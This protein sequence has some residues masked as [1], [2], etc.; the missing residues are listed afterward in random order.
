MKN[1]VKRKFE[2]LV[3][4]LLDYNDGLRRIG[5]KPCFISTDNTLKIVLDMENP[6]TES[7]FGIFISQLY[8]TLYE[9]SRYGNNLPND[10]D[11]TLI[12]DE[13]VQL[14]HEYGHDRLV[15]NEREVLKKQMKI[16][17]ILKK[18][19][20]TRTPK[21]EAFLI[22]ASELLN[23]IID[24]MTELIN[25][26]EKEH[27]KYNRTKFI[28]MMYDPKKR[29]NI[30]Q[31]KLT[32]KGSYER[33]SVTPIFVPS[34][35][36]PPEIIPEREC[37]YIPI[38]MWLN[39]NSIKGVK[40]FISTISN[41]W[42]KNLSN[43]MYTQPLFSWSLSDSKGNMVYGYGKKS[44]SKNLKNLTRSVL[45]I[46]FSGDYGK[47]SSDSLMVIGMDFRNDR[48]RNCFVDFYLSSIPLDTH[49]LES[50]KLNLHQVANNISGGDS[51]NFIKT[52]F[53]RWFSPLLDLP[54]DSIHTLI[55]KNESEY[56]SYYDYGV[57]DTELV[58]EW[59]LETEWGEV[60][61][62]NNPFEGLDE[63]VGFLS[64]TLFDDDYKNQDLRV[65]RLTISQF[66][67]PGRGGIIPI[68][69]GKI[70]LH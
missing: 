10:Q 13:V 67:V 16:G 18:Y 45:T 11:L 34:A 49:W 41:L 31:R 2:S 23:N 68:I 4:L 55:G 32:K 63:L 1:D 12:I 27:K 20:E 7:K 17:E 14:R 9:S 35:H 70:V 65:I 52:N 58:P 69:F 50:F 53:K 19:T 60:Y 29:K 40:Q 22:L 26:I 21:N 25:N 54:I 33:L 62:I 28:N 48:A 36:W 47:G 8:K 59:E 61:S 24:A 64:P 15:G 37:V 44:L 3:R 56:D 39:D 57:Y 38:D 5:K 43:V 42:T 66:N 46:V 51:C 30:T 6:N